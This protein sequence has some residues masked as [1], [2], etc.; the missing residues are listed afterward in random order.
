MPKDTAPAGAAGDDLPA[1]KRPQE[2]VPTA[3][4]IPV[5]MDAAVANA[6]NQQHVETVRGEDVRADVV[7]EPQNAVENRGQ[8][9]QNAAAAEQVQMAAAGND[10]RQHGP[11]VL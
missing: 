3:G 8:D 2:N 11:V 6:V 4:P 5:P 10:A 7:N 9:Q 1:E